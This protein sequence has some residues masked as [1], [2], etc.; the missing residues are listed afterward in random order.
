MPSA[1]FSLREEDPE[2]LDLSEPL[3]AEIGI[4]KQS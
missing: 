1:D 4:R 3:Q 2:E